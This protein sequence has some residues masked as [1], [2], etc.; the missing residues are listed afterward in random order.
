VAAVAVSPRK[1]RV[2]VHDA[3]LETWTTRSP[4]GVDA[5]V[6]SLGGQDQGRLKSR[7]ISIPSERHQPEGRGDQGARSAEARPG[8][9][10]G[11]PTEDGE[12]RRGGDLAAA[13]M[14]EETFGPPSSGGSRRNIAEEICRRIHPHR[15]GPRRPRRTRISAG[16]V[17]QPHP[18]GEIATETAMILPL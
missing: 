18:G 7:G 2:E 4:S 10:S 15:R 16:A 3:A 13:A 6:L 9:G 5:G 8:A 12:A 11:F 14:V 1:L 17:V